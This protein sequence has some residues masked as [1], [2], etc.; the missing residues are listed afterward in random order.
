[1][2][3]GAVLKHIITS[4]QGEQELSKTGAGK[5]AVLHVSPALSHGVW[6][7]L[8]RL[9]ACERSAASL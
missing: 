4:P 1:M 6:R 8:L 2:R 7:L 5:R 9:P 3:I